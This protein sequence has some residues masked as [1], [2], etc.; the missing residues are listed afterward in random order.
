MHSCKM[1]HANFK[2]FFV[3]PPLTC[4]L[5][6][7]SFFRAESDLLRKPHGC[8]MSGY[9]SPLFPPP[10]SPGGL[11][12]VTGEA[13]LVFGKFSSPEDLSGQSRSVGSVWHLFQSYGK[14]T[15]R[16]ENRPS[17]RCL[18][19]TFWCS[20]KP[21]AAKL[22]GGKSAFAFVSW[23]PVLV[24]PGYIFHFGLWGFAL[25]TG[26]KAHKTP[27]S[28]YNWSEWDLLPLICCSSRQRKGGV[29][30]T[31]LCVRQKLEVGRHSH[32]VKCKDG[33]LVKLD[34][35]KLQLLFSLLSIMGYQ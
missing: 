30:V 9:A 22:W 1:C 35:V 24:L 33:N 11:A 17:I 27:G 6:L 25:M 8:A 34:S 23:S 5:S 14:E 26:W 13:N 18:H 15:P 4:W 31:T 32:F 12:L 10:G 20:T 3:K 28:H 19:P 7:F 29:G 16:A 2:C 21:R